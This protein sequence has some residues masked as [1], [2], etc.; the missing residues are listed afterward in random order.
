MKSYQ[1]VKAVIEDLSVYDTTKKGLF[2][3]QRTI[4]AADYK[5]ITGDVDSI[6]LI[7]DEILKY[8]DRL[9]ELK[10]QETN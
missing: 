2:Q 1:K 9:S 6:L 5:R 4:S 3:S 10:V 7:A 8:N